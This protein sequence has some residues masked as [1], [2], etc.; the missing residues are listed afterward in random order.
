MVIT[1]NRTKSAVLNLVPFSKR[2]D[3]PFPWKHRGSGDRG[4]K[5]GSSGAEGTGAAVEAVATVATTLADNNSNGG[6]RQQWWKQRQQQGQK[7]TN[8]KVAAIAAEPAVLEA[9]A[10]E[11]AIV[12][13]MAMAVVI[14]AVVA[15]AMTPSNNK[16]CL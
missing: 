10:A 4:R 13:A 8:Q 5:I 6:G 11:M 15:V 1:K 14:V 16:Y 2:T 3:P 12:A 9:W 7:I